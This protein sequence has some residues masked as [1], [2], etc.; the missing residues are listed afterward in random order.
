LH[1]R[2]VTFSST[3][4]AL[5]TEVHRRNLLAAV[6]HLAADY[7]SRLAIDGLLF[8]RELLRRC[9]ATRRTLPAGQ[10]LV[11]RLRIEMPMPVEGVNADPRA[12]V[13]EVLEIVAVGGIARRNEALTLSQCLSLIDELPLLRGTDRNL[14]FASALGPGVLEYERVTSIRPRRNDLDGLFPAQAECGLES[15]GE[16]RCTPCR[17]DES[18]TQDSTERR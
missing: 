2:C 8:R 3:S 14:A 5:T 1:Q 6:A 9:T 15:F 10:F 7:F 16:E 13:A 18:F 12:L 4:I 17:A 11:A